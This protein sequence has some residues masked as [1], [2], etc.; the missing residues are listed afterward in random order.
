MIN[1]VVLTGRLVEIPELRYTPNNKAVTR[2][3]V[4]VDRPYRKDVEKQADFIKI[5]AWGSTA[6]FVCRYFSKGQKIAVIGSI[7]TGSYEKDGIKRYTTEVYA[8]KVDFVESKAKES[9]DKPNTSNEYSNNTETSQSTNTTNTDTYDYESAQ[10]EF[11]EIPTSY[12][13]DLP[14]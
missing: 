5:V 11:E 4:A 13:D 12:S 3:T 2:F 8:E 9:K 1:N 10:Q 6:E 14:F 7:R